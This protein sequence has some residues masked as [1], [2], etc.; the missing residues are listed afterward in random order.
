MRRISIQALLFLVAGAGAAGPIQAGIIYNYD[1]ALG[2]LPEAQGFTRFENMPGAPP[3]TVSGGVLHQF[4]SADN[5]SQ[6][7]YANS[8]P[9]DFA[10]T[11]YVLEANLHVISS[12]YIPNI[13]TGQRSGYYLAAIDAVGHIFAVGIASGGITINTDAGFDPN[14]GVPFTSFDTTDAFHMYR[15]IIADGMGTL[16]IDGNLFVATPLGVAGL[17]D[18]VLDNRVLFGDLSGQGASETELHS[19]GFLSV[20]EPGSLWL[21]GVGL[22][23]LAAPGHFGLRRAMA[24]RAK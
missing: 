23:I 9:L 18:P 13:G 24:P 1:P 20:P 2:T 4:R 19:F 21:A 14:N 12:D 22:G 3:P 7:W 17:V 6:F 10:T 11:S 16:F 8:V 5:N 15:L